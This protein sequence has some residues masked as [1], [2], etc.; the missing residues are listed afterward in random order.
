MVSGLIINHLP[1]LHHLR[2]FQLF[3]E[4]IMLRSYSEQLQ[5]IMLSICFW[6]QY[7]CYTNNCF[8]SPIFIKSPIYEKFICSALNQF[9][10]MIN[11]TLQKTEIYCQLNPLL[12]VH[13]TGRTMTLYDSSLSEAQFCHS[14]KTAKVC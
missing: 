9:V 6:K 1:D 8:T 10:S 13:L 5:W 12:L 4:P 3:K 7:R 2:A 14:L 11:I